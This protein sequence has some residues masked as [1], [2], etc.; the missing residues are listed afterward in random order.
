MDKNKELKTSR[1]LSLVLRHKPEL[2][3]VTL[4]KEGWCPI[5]KVLK[6]CNINIDELIYIVNN[7]S[8]GR[9]SF[10]DNMTKIRANQGHSVKDVNLTFKELVPP[11]VLYHGTAN[12]YLLSILNTGLE[13]RTRQYVHLSGDLE[14]ASNV[15][16]RHGTLI[17]LKI[18]AKRMYEDGYKFYLSDNGVWLCD[19]VPV[20]YISVL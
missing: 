6:G 9:Y 3:N 16:K 15:G 19:C 5:E 4:E 14:T 2:I 11:N 13:K 18:N 8:K 12:K 20:K 1:F 10:N 7:D 17:I